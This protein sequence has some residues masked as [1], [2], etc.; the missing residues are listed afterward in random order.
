MGSGA[1][2][3]SFCNGRDTGEAAKGPNECEARQ[4]QILRCFG[5]GGFMQGKHTGSIG[6]MEVPML[7][8]DHKA[9]FSK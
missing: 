2:V 9:F 6:T 5:L 8:K 4:C 1:V 3:A 7:D